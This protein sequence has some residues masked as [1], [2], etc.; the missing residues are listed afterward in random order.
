MP[1]GAA[2]RTPSPAG[3][4]LRAGVPMPELVPPRPCVA[5]I[6]K[7][8]GGFRSSFG[9]KKSDGTLVLLRR[10]RRFMVGSASIS[11]TDY[12]KYRIVPWY[13][14]CVPSPYYFFF[15]YLLAPCA[16]RYFHG[17]HA[18]GDISTAAHRN[19]G[20]STA[21]GVSYIATVHMVEPV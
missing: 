2:P 18:L 10:G 12:A 20:V 21:S 16:W 6:K 19:E 7:E 15:L 1:G 13:S 9:F 14:Q 17:C 11:H 5:K 8:P 3:A 4:A